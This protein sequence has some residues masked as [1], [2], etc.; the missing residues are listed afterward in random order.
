MA[1][2]S[3]RW[4]IIG[5]LVLV[6]LFYGVHY[7]GAKVVVGEI[8][9]RAYVGVR[10]YGGALLLLL[11]CLATRR[12]LPTGGGTLWRLG[13][14]AIFGVILNQ[15]LFAE[16]IARTTP[17]HSS[18]INTTIPLTTL[19]LAVAIGRERLTLRRIAAVALG[20]TGALL[21]IRPSPTGLGTGTIGDL[22]T[23][24]NATSFSLFLVISRPLMKRVDPLA[25]STVLL[26]W[27][28]VGISA[29]S[30][31]SMLATDWSAVSTASWGWMAFAVICVTALAY[32]LQYWALSQVE[33]SVV[34]FFI[35]LQPTLAALLSYLRFGEQ[36]DLW[37]VGGAT[38]IFTG[39][40]IASRVTPS[41]PAPRR[42]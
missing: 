39:V 14:F 41:A 10:I 2:K 35:Y 23:W 19:L 4:L 5:A 9:P 20:L 1:P 28:A 25:A 16:G 22:L 37:I 8:S 15:W 32:V 12:Q 13:I 34:A 27:G 30:L 21:I 36:L 40:A 3:P 6:Q 33:S 38:L 26:L 17:I 7:V 31:P 11:Y 42:S 18:L 29:I 24:A